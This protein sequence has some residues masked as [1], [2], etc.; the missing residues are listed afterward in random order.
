[1]LAPD[2]REL[3]LDS[4]RPPDGM[5]LDRAVGTTFTLDLHALLVTPLAF[6]LFDWAID[7]NGAPNIVAILEGLRRHADRITVFCQAGQIRLPKYQPALTFLEDRVI[8]VTPPNPDRIFHP[9]AWLLRFVPADGDGPVHYRVLCASRNLTFDRSWD[10]LLR[11]DGAV[12]DGPVNDVGLGSFVRLLADLTSDDRPD[13]HADLETML[14]ELPRVAFD[15][16]DGFRDVQF[17]V[18]DGDV[19]PFPSNADRA[20]VVS[21]FLTAGALARL[22]SA[23]APAEDVLV[24]R[25]E[26]LDRTPIEGWE[27]RFV[28]SPLVVQPDA[29]SVSAD[30]D[31]ASEE[32]DLQG[33]HAKL[34]LFEQGDT[35][36]VFTGSAN[37]TDAAFSGNIELLAE[38][39]TARAELGIDHLL[40]HGQ[41]EPRFRDLLDV[42]PP[43]GATDV[44]GE[45]AEQL[46]QVLDVA[47]RRFGAMSFVARYRSDGDDLYDLTLEASGHVDVPPEVDRV[48]C[49]RISAGAGHA[50]TVRPD[51]GF[52]AKFGHVAGA[53]ITA[54]F[55]IEVT[56]RVGQRGDS[57]VFVVTAQLLG[58]PEGRR[59][60]VLTDLLTSRFDVLQ[61]LLFLLA[62]LDGSGIDELAAALAGD[63]AG[64]GAVRIDPAGTPLLESLLR[65]L[66]HDPAKLDHVASLMDE[67]RSSGRAEDL[68]PDHLDEIWGPIWQVRQETDS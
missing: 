55:A 41:G 11:L 24:S 51:Y 67:L 6:A 39:T 52:A 8:P 17:R 40:L 7:D 44:E 10:T 65:A 26:T 20:L 13:V 15:P 61:Y 23:A 12:T 4:L 66:R 35:T 19:W 42:H 31:A 36:R 3:L 38:M 48:R 62:D 27:P 43:G 21:P 1:M 33:L 45:E 50:V 32:G 22:G 60:R 5:H 53:G 46:E 59:Q 25:P 16:P 57:R 63:P 9:K 68:V 14:A 2:D 30:D 29:L 49:W 56:A 37:A 58:A 64:A 47:S 28:L 18:L 54:F 34:F